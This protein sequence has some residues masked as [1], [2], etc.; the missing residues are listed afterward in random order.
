ML[1]GNPKFWKETKIKLLK[2][3]K[4]FGRKPKN[5]RMKFDTSGP[6]G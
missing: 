3:T 4:N 1:E 5:L 2:Q 6:V